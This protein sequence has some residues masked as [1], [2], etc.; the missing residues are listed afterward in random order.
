M[1]AL[2]GVFASIVVSTPPRH[3]ELTSS[4]RTT[5]TTT[6]QSSSSFFSLNA[7]RIGRINIKGMGKG[8]IRPTA[9]PETTGGGGGSSINTEADVVAGM[10]QGLPLTRSFPQLFIKTRIEVNTCESVGGCFRTAALPNLQSSP[11]AVT[12]GK[13]T[14]PQN[15]L[16][17]DES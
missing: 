15:C 7:R 4:S 16:C 12:Q 2:H 5:T 14:T 6:S 8:G 3:L 1:A 17:V 11:P 10:W 9:T 13:S